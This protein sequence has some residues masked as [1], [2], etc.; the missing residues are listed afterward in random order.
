MLFVSEEAVLAGDAAVADLIGSGYD[1][2]GAFA[3]GLPALAREHA[4]RAFCSEAVGTWLGGAGV[5]TAREPWR[6][7]PIGLLD[8]L[9]LLTL[10]DND[11]G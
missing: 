10:K 2:W 8:Y 7:T 5:L 4:D 3:A 6:L 1:W 11:H 9:P